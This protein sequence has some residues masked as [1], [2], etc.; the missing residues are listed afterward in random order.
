MNR[1]ITELSNYPAISVIDYPDLL[2][3]ARSQ[4]QEENL[5]R[6]K[7]YN[8]SLETFVDAFKNNLSAFPIDFA[9]TYINNNNVSSKVKNQTV[10]ASNIQSFVFNEYGCVTDF[11]LKDADQSKRKFYLNGI[12]PKERQ[13]YTG[14]NITLLDFAI[15]SEDENAGIQKVANKVIKY[16]PGYNVNEIG[17]L[18]NLTV[19][20]TQQVTITTIDG[21]IETGNW[22]LLFLL[23]FSG[24]RKTVINMKTKS[25]TLRRFSTITEEYNFVIDWVRM[26][27]SGNGM[28]S[29]GPIGFPIS[30]SYLNTIDQNVA[31]EFFIIKPLDNFKDNPTKNNLTFPDLLSGSFLQNST[32]TNEYGSNNVT[33]SIRDISFSIGSFKNGENVGSYGQED[34]QKRIVSLPFAGITNNE[35]RIVSMDVSNFA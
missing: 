2:L 34:I 4:T 17:N 19:P 11:N 25:Q 18:A 3:Y 24:Y 7:N 10:N 23:D 1:S 12:L 5:G 27:A 16:F 31:G 6:I 13:R 30:F 9:S 35:N 33:L 28:V 15:A 29:M 21:N 8:T 22:D 32:L 20:E 26:I 14:G